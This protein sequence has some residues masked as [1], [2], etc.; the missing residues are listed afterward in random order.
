ML[1]H[2][3]SSSVIWECKKQSC[4]SNM[5]VCAYKA[6]ITFYFHKH[7]L[8]RRSLTPQFP[9]FCQEAQASVSDPEIKITPVKHRST[10]F[11]TAQLIWGKTDTE[12]NVWIW[13]WDNIWWRYEERLFSVISEHIYGHLS[14]MDTRD[15]DVCMFRWRGTMFMVNCVNQ[16]TGW[17]SAYWSDLNN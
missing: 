7:A 16:E 17:E 12:E 11:R 10:L 15:P 14:L 5:H 4:E 2:Q 8:L 13:L 9:V 1:P 6:Q 3:Y